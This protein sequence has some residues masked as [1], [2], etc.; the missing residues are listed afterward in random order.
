MTTKIAENVY[1]VGAV[2]WEV[3]NFHGHTYHTHRGTSYNA[4]LI[5]DDHIA[6][7][8]TVMQGFEDDMFRRIA[9][10]V[11]PTGIDYLVANHGELDHSGAIPA[12]LARAPKAQL[13]CSKKAVETLS[14]YFPNEREYHVVG[15]GDTIS[16]GQ[17]TLSFLEAP[18]LHWP[19]SMFTYIPEDRVLLPMDAFGQHLASTSRFADEV[20]PA[21]LWDEARKYFANI[22]TPFSRLILRKVEEVQTLGLEIDVIA[23]SHGLIWR[24]EPLQIVEQY[25]RWSRGD[26]DLRALV[27]YETMWGSTAEIAQ[28]IAE[29]IRDS[30]VEAQVYPVPQT[31]HT[32]VVGHLLEARGIVVGSATH[33]R[34]ALLNISLLV[35]DLIGLRPVGKIGAAFGSQGWGGGATR[36]LEQRLTEAGVEVVQEGLSL[37]WRPNVEEREQ[38]VAF[39]R[40]FGRQVLAAQNSDS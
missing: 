27:V 21:I 33:N 25:V 18:M 7:V 29:G 6:L 24:K 34:R 3:R 14:S 11:D 9:E 12:V 36:L 15:T 5:I 26:A 38:A 35:E 4:Y 32:T 17:K 30:G 31:D 39:G 13:V 8:D 37:A 2:D 22:L 23:P 40:A 28:A 10:V 19:D 1:W 20:E 16:L